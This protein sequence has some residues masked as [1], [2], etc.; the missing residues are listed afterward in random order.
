MCRACR[1]WGR[2]LAAV[3][4]NEVDDIRRFQSAQKLCGYIGLCPTTTSSGGKTYHGKLMRACNK[5]LRWAFTSRLGSH[6]LLPVFWRSL[7]TQARRG[8][9]SQHRHPVEP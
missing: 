4:V 2:I 5:W 3:V 7:Q 8:Q 6:R 1:A 9:E